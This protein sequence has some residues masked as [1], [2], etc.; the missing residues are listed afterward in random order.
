MAHANLTLVVDHRVRTDR[1]RQEH[2]ATDHTGRA[3]AG[4]AA[5][6]SGVR[7]NDDVIF[8]RRVALLVREL[9]FDAER[10]QGYALIDLHAIADPRGL[11]DDDARRVV[12]EKRTAEV[13]TR[14]DIAS[15][16]LVRVLGDQPGHDRYPMSVQL[17]RDSVRGD[18]KEARVGQNH[19]VGGFGRRVTIRDELGILGEAFADRDRACRRTHR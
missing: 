4:L 12:D 11:A 6:H 5:E 3:D 10:P 13:S 2:V 1:F 19:L 16:P 9:L 17:I 7:V 18:R 15:R 8:D 14:M